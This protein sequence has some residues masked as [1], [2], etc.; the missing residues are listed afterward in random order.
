MKKYPKIVQADKRGQIVIPKDIR[1]ELGLDE[2]SGFWMFAV[3]KEGIL[4]KKVA[5]PDIE[6]DPLIDHIEQKS[7][8]IGID[9][10]TIEHTKTQYKKTKDGNLDLI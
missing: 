2:G 7:Q 6:H 5:T 4:L 9:T 3:G 8:K 10:K 1:Q